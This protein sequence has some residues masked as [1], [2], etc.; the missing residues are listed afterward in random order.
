M[1]L[2][3]GMRGGKVG[4]I[5]LLFALLLTS[6]FSYAS[7][8]W[9]T[10][11]TPLVAD[12]R[13]VGSYANGCLIG[14]VALPLEG[15]GFQVVR[16]ERRRYFAHPDTLNFVQRLGLYAKA[17]LHAS[18]MIADVGLPRGGRFAYGHASH[19]TGL[20]VDVWLKLNSSPLEIQRLAEAKTESLV[21]VKAQN[22]DEAVWRDDYF[23]LVKKAAED[24][25]VARIFINP[26]IKERLCVMEKSD[27][28]DWLRKV[29]PWWGHSA[30]MHVRLKCPQN[31][32]ECVSQPLPPEG[33]GCGEEVTSW[34]IRPTPPPQKPSSPPPTPE[35]CLRVLETDRAP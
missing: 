10:V 21:D 25:R 27:E 14:A 3:N 20:D 29:R 5:Y 4:K 7:T 1:T 31:S 17:T 28:R 2:D 18:L 6:F 12:A 35:V 19:Q 26:V 8:P 34:R 9:E 22:I 30:H 13:A 15:E 32:D 11:S 24:E 16:A 23:E 33:D